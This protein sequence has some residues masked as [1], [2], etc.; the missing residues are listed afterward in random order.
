MKERDVFPFIPAPS[1]CLGSICTWRIAGEPESMRSTYPTHCGI[2]A[3]KWDH[4]DVLG[5]E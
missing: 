4:T 1:I 3:S 2:N 5:T